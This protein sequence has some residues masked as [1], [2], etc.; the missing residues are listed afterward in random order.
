MTR[1]SRDANFRMVV[2]SAYDNRCAVTRAQMRL[3]DAAHILPVPAE[4]SSDQVS[5]GIS[6]APTLHRAYDNGLIYLDSDLV[7]RMNEERADHLA[8]DGLDAGLA[9]FRR[10]LDRPIHL[11]FDVAQRPRAEYI[12]RANTYRR[13]PG[14]V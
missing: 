2:L 12:V 14:Y 13:I 3:V 8:V 5:N 4:G 11:P 10:L 9:D 6:L 1:Y 7:M